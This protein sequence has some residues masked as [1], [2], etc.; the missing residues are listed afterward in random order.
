MKTKPEMTQMTELV[1]K[2]IKSYCNYILSVQ[3]ARRMTGHVKYRHG[4]YF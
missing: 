2:Q 4:K 1:A 3:G